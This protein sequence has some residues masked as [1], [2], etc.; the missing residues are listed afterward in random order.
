MIHAHVE[1]E[2]SIKNATGHDK[3]KDALNKRS[4]KLRIFK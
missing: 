2:R 1:V 4:L 3:I